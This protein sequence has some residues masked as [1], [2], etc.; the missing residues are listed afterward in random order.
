MDPFH[1]IHQEWMASKRGDYSLFTPLRKSKTIA[2]FLFVVQGGTFML[3][4]YYAPL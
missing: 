2:D 4:K 3:C 1:K